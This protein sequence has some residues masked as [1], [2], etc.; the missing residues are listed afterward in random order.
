MEP[1]VNDEEPDKSDS[2]DN[3]YKD[4]EPIT[5]APELQ[6][7]QQSHFLSQEAPKLQNSQSHKSD[8]NSKISYIE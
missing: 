8:D 3:A 6:P 7:V 5:H 4:M 1:I 2:F